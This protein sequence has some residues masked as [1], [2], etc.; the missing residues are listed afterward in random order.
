[1]LQ[2]DA[3]AGADDTATILLAEDDDAVRALL[4]RVLRLRGYSVVVAVDGAEAV[5]VAMSYGRPF[6]LLITDV[7]MPK[8]DGL[9]L[10]AQLLSSGLAQ[11]VIYMTGYADA[12]LDAQGEA[13]VLHKPFT[14]S[15]LAEAVRAALS[16]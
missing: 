3:L 11:R 6:Q 12:L 4:V 1:M 13:T 10:A 5:A 9:A 8:M 7:M 2:H 16:R 14:P 15:T